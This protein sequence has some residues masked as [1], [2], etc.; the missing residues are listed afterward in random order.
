MRVIFN[1]GID[2]QP[3]SLL[4]PV[5]LFLS[6]NVSFNI[7]NSTLWYFFCM[8]NIIVIY[9]VAKRL[10]S[11][12]VVILIVSFLVVFSI[13]YFGFVSMSDRF[14]YNIDTALIAFPFFC[15]GRLDK[16]Y[17]NFFSRTYRGKSFVILLALIIFLYLILINGK[18]DLNK[19]DFGNNLFFYYLN[20]FLGVFITLHISRLLQ[21]KYTCKFLKWLSYNAIFIFPSH[22]VVY[23]LITG[24]LLFFLDVNTK[25]HSG[26]LFSLFYII[27][28][29]LIMSVL[30]TLWPKKLNF[31]IGK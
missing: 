24:F 19:L 14:H 22:V 16:K 30:I 15:V 28:T 5:Y 18:V 21:E 8:F 3:S 6:G 13:I 2:D 31:I 12:E 9:M 1:I 10:T 29:L 17:L 25:D 20:S 4:F 7:V 27:V 23:S 26:F 11:N